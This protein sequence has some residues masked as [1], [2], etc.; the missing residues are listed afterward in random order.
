MIII[1]LLLLVLLM[2]WTL[3]WRATLI[4]YETSFT[5]EGSHGS[6]HGETVEN[7]HEWR[8]VLPFLYRL[9][10]R[11]IL[12]W[13]T[14]KLLICPSKTE[15]LT[16]QLFGMINF[17]CKGTYK[18]VLNRILLME[19]SGRAEEIVRW[20]N[21]R[22]VTVFAVDLRFPEVSRK[23]FVSLY[24][25]Q[26]RRWWAESERHPRQIFG[27]SSLRSLVSRHRGY[28]IRVCARIHFVE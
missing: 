13:H 15:I 7:R 23:K 9:V 2:S 18:H 11:Y 10:V 24:D 21:K 19:I 3:D 14:S 22:F 4:I 17:F 5:S 25:T 16:M 12:L 28:Q 8:A 26:L 20:K 27:F 1:S 6:E